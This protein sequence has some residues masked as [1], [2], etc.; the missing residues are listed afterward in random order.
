MA[1]TTA[2]FTL[3]SPDLV[4]TPISLSSTAT[5]YDAGTTTGVT[6]VKMGKNEIP[7]GSPTN[8]DL[9]NATA[10]HAN[11]ANKFYIANKATNED[12]YVVITIGA[13]II[14]RLYAGD[15]MFMPWEAAAA[16][17]DIEIQAYESAQHIEWVV[18]HEGETLV[19]AS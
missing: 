17:Q 2:T 6:Q 11:K 9:L 7:L 8:F 5:L 1:T 16:T 15:W 19:T 12:H 13:Q 14:G 4:S 18:F 10:A 3:S